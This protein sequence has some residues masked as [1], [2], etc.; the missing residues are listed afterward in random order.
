[1]Y[2]E[3]NS[4]TK[5]GRSALIKK[6]TDFAFSTG[7]IRVGRKIWS[8]SLTVLN[9]HRI[10]DPHRKDFD[11]FQ[12]N[13]SAHPIEFSR[14]MEYLS[15][16][17]NVVSLRDVMNWLNG[18]QSLPPYAALITFDDGYLDN[19][20]NAYPILLQ[21]KFP[22]VIYLTTGHINTDAPFYWDLAAYCF[23]HT[24]ID[25]ILFPNGTDVFWKNKAE[26]SQVSKNW[27]NSMKLLPEMEK[28][29]WVAGLPEKL[30]VAVPHNFFRN[31]MI[32]WDQA[33]EMFNNGI[34]FGGHTVNHPILTRIPLS[35]AQIQIEE[36]KTKIEK[37]LGQPIFSFAY[38]N[39]LQADLNPEIQKIVANAGYKAAFTLQN[40][41][42]TLQ[43]VKLNPF[44]IRRVF[45]SHSH[46]L[47]QFST[48]TSMFNRLR[49][50]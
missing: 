12:P 1:M 24:K 49:P 11:S 41:P 5:F 36:S 37:E 42:A 22:A 14:Q 44:T 45:I 34:E 23:H 21:Y 8:K 32:N 18:T 3:K 30:N 40:G 7:A 15:R 20:E 17:F 29:N 28:K 6:L 19:Y 2:S 26:L 46:T 27:I 38:P 50:S 16:W 10:D 4:P 25:H 9:Y 31:L 47:S 33:R 13:I 43:E 35:E 48:I 39:G